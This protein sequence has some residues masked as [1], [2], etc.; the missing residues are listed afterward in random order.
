MWEQESCRSP[1]SPSCGCQEEKPSKQA[2]AKLGPALAFSPRGLPPALL[3]PGPH[4]LCSQGRTWVG[5]PCKTLGAH[6]FIGT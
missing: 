3:H 6:G 5:F 1:Q 2:E 4:D